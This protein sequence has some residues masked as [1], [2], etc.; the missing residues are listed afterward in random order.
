MS[1]THT[2]LA[3]FPDYQDHSWAQGC[4]VAIVF[5]QGGDGRVVGAG[6]RVEGFA[7]LHLVMLH[8]AE[9]AFTDAVWVAARGA[10]GASRLDCLACHLAFRL[11]SA[12]YGQDGDIRTFLPARLLPFRWFQT[13]II[14][15]ETPKFSATDSTVSPLRIL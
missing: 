8:G 11:R 15:T 7:L 2:D 1:K 12:R 6:N 3:D 5:F 10:V 14:F 4:Y 13:R 9:A